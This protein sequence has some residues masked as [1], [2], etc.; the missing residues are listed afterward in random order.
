MP[1]YTKNGKILAP[2]T[3]EE[4]AQGM[5]T[6]YFVEEY[7][8]A[9]VVLLFY[10]GVR[11]AEALRVV[12]QQFT[13][14]KENIIFSV[15]K[16]LKHGIE[17]PPLTLPQKLPYIQYLLQLIQKPE[18]EHMKLFDFCPKT[19]YN[20]VS[21]VFHYPH[22]FR[23]SRITNFFAEGYSIA[24]VRTWTGLTLK[25]LDFYIGLVD[26]KTMGESLLK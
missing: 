4:F 19:A 16:R 14:T 26:I 11:C 25:S 13:L 9:F 17:T 24:Q 15:L 22:F 20:I 6:G 1:N 10:T 12:K 2:M 21:R 23:L 5:E 7:H 8:K 3:D 18:G